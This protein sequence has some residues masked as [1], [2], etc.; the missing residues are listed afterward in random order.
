MVDLVTLS[1]R[2]GYNIDFDTGTTRLRFSSGFSETA[3]VNGTIIL[4]PVV[5]V[6]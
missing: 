3:D 2:T 4:P 5:T 6:M 1:C